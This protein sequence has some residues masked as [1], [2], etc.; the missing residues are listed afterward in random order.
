MIHTR[1][2]LNYDL[3]NTLCTSPMSQQPQN[4]SDIKPHC[5][6]DMDVE[7]KVKR[8]G[9]LY[10]SL[11]SVAMQA[12]CPPLICL[13]RLQEDRKNTSRE[14]WK[15]TIDDLCL[16]QLH[17]STSACKFT[18]AWQF[19][20]EP[21]A[22]KHHV[23]LLH[24]WPHHNLRPWLKGGRYFYA[25]WLRGGNIVRCACGGSEMSMTEIQQKKK[26]REKSQS[27]PT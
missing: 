5:E 9:S 12:L 7:W 19:R 10:N 27:T 26:E 15:A 24:I 13:S 20:A 23:A 4:D 16:T 17:L 8:N 2:F 11:S 3:N 1:L 25:H 22:L 6:N 14:G 21:S 18:P